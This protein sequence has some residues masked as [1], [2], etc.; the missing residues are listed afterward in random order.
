[1]LER[2][3]SRPPPRRQPGAISAKWLLG[4]VDHTLQ[5]QPI[6]EQLSPAEHPLLHCTGFSGPSLPAQQIQPV[7]GSV[8]HS[9]PAAGSRPVEV[10]LALGDN[11]PVAYR[12]NVSHNHLAH[13]K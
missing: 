6:L 5:Q 10:M 12:A 7:E 9:F 2:P 1:M 3:I 13:G 11:K 8:L 4:T